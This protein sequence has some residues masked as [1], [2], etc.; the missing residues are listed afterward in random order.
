MSQ[1]DI[2]HTTVT[3]PVPHVLGQLDHVDRRYGLQTVG[4][5]LDHLVVDPVQKGD[6]GDLVVVW[7]KKHGP[8][9]ARRLARCEPY[10]TFHFRDLGTGQVFELPCNKVATIHAVVSDVVNRK[11][12]A[13]R[14]LSPRLGRPGRGFLLGMSASAC[15]AFDRKRNSWQLARLCRSHNL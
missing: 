1:A 7:R 9:V 2:Q 5:Q 12:T 13:P 11:L 6:P 14:S 15:F 10:N 8:M 3:T 4:G